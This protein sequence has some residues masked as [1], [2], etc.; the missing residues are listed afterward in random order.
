MGGQRYISS[1]AARW[2]VGGREI[3]L[4]LL[5]GGGWGGRDISLAMLQGEGGG[6]QRDLVYLNVSLESVTNIVTIKTS[7]RNGV[8]FYRLVEYVGSADSA[9]RCNETESY[10][11]GGGGGCPG[12]G[13]WVCAGVQ[14]GGGDTPPLVSSTR[15]VS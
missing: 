7:D 14:G 15:G 9:N 11:G 4:A 12:E 6:G 8:S 5:Q 1:L 3:S 10:D 2:G 13:V